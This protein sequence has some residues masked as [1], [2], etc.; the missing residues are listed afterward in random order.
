MNDHEDKIGQAL[1]D[2]ARKDSVIVKQVGGVGGAGGVGLH[3]ELAMASL[4]H[5][6]LLSCNVDLDVTTNALSR[7]TREPFQITFIDRVG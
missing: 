7:E 4:I 6:T 3:G 1:I 5:V 2:V